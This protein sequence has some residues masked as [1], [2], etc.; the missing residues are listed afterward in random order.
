MASKNYDLNASQ[1]AFTQDLQSKGYTADEA[2]RLF[3]NT[4]AR[5]VDKIAEEQ[6]TLDNQFRTGQ[7]DYQKQA[8]LWEQEY[9]T[10]LFD[11]QQKQDAINRSDASE[12]FKK[13]YGLKMSQFAVEKKQQIWEN[14]YRNKTYKY[15]V[16]KDQ[17]DREA[18]DIQQNIDTDYNNRVLEART[19]SEQ[20]DLLQRKA[21]A[22][23]QADEH[24]KEVKIKNDE[25]AWSKSK[26]N[27]ALQAQVLDNK[28]K[29][30]QIDIANLEKKNLPEKE[31]LEI[32]QLK[33]SLVK[34]TVQGKSQAALELEKK[35][36]D[37]QQA[38]IDNVK[39]KTEQINNPKDST[40][41]TA[42]PE[43]S[44]FIESTYKSKN[45]DGNYVIDKGKV[46]TYLDELEKSGVDASIIDSLANTY[47]R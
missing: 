16:E 21:E 27:P 24:A 6:R 19:E 36:V 35:K 43:A 30:V 26:D 17:T 45:A 46:G 11:Y 34:P 9:K 2:Q 37:Y 29:Q 22:K 38:L 40:K 39:A 4:R 44:K 1:Q 41:T 32:A 31:R 5:N 47:A 23:Q 15:Q 42:Y 3:E 13:E 7:F 33:A 28:Y 10:G 25:F 12:Q 8:D 20:S 18:A 14:T